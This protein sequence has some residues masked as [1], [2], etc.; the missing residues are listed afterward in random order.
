M[1]RQRILFQT[2]KKP[3]K[4]TNE[5][6]VNYLPDKEFKALVIRMLPELGKRIDELEK[7]GGREAV[8]T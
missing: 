3:R 7:W 5:T 4:P 8:R 6:E 2:K 1:R